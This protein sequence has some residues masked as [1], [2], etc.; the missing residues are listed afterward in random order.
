MTT[1]AS[2]GLLRN[3]DGPQRA[4]LL[5]LIF[6]VVYVAA[7]ALMSTR[8]A[9]N[10]SWAGAARLLV[11]LAAI[12]WIWSI[13]ALLTD[14]YDPQR[15]PIQAMI[16]GTMFGSVLMTA[17]LPFAFSEHGW[18]FAGAYVTIHVGR[19]LVLVSALR[20]HPNAQHRAGR[21]LFWFGISGIAW[22]AG[23]FAM[24]AARGAL[25]VVALTIDYV[26]GGLRYPTPRI[27]RVPLDQYDKARE[28]LG[29][30]YQQFV[31][32]ALGDLILVPTLKIA[33]T[34]FTSE[35]IGALL[36]AFVTTMLLWQIYVYRAGAFLQ[37]AIGKR[38]GRV[39]RWAPYTHLVLLTGLVATAAGFELV[40]VRPTGETPPSWIGIIVGGP[41]LFLIGRTIF[42]Y[43]V[44]AA[45]S[46]S[47]LVW[48]VVL[49]AAAPPMVL[50]P[51]LLVTIVTSAILLGI[52]GSDAVRASRESPEPLTQPSSG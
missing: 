28:H 2:T 4:T 11:V 51:P 17:T 33:G 6:D 10:L 21:F 46:W 48:L 5:E 23:T 1:G 29:E 30:R 15:L 40:I 19:G 36:V 27:G 18:I 25:W 47:R 49:L 12:W 50:L 7:I 35:R 45:I 16:A 32:L 39:A 14:F 13:T 52:A 20:R 38:P 3:P 34:D 8:L 43:E 41:A 44:F 24:G 9:S 42:E 37:A 26:A 31:I 22:I